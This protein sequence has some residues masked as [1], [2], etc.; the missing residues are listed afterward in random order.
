MLFLKTTKTKKMSYLQNATGFLVDE[1]GDSLDPSPPGQASNCWLGD[2][3]DVI[4]QHFPV[5]FGAALSQSFP[6]FSSPRHG[7]LSSALT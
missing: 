5:P 7:D 4:T 3:L 1:T 2:P 6:A